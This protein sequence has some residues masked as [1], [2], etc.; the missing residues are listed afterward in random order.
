VRLPAVLAAATLAAAVLP[1]A[2]PAAAAAQ[3]PL[4]ASRDTARDA[5][6]FSFEARGPYRAAVPRPEA[7]LGY[8]LGDRNT[9]Y[10]EQE[11]VLLAIARAAPDRVRVE[12]I[13]AT[14]EGRRMRVYVVSS[15]ENVARLDAIR[16]DL[17]RLADP[18]TL[19]AADAAALAARTPAVVWISESV[20]G[21]ES[22]GFETGMQLL[23]QLAAS[24]E[25]ATLA[26]LRGAVVVINPSS[27]PDGHERFAVWYNSVARSD[28]AN[29]AAEHREPWSIQG[30]VQP[31]PV[32][33]EPR[34]D[35]Q[36]A[37]RGA[38]DH[39][40]H[41][42]LAPAGGRRPAR[43]GGHLLLPARGRAGQPQHR[44]GEREVAHGHRPRQRGGV[45]PL[46]LAVLRARP[47]R[48]VLP[49]LLGHLAVAHRRHRDDVRDRRRRLEGAALAARRR[50]AAVVPRRHRQALGVGD[51][52]DRGDGAARRP[53]ARR[54]RRLPPRGVDAGRAGPMR[55]VVW[56][57]APTR[58]AP[59]S[60][61]RRSCAPASR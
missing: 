13:G 39:A 51:G 27:N 52:D 7:L 61:R 37:A 4:A 20:H 22:P 12:E 38:G 40:R 59:P 10:A 3:P 24:E 11:R 47:V 35:R 18:R 5:A 60:W 26:A 29:D 30:P 17:A 50:L 33:H 53:S 57:P 41:A 6:R 2:R 49:G 48:P 56:C 28:P 36:H 43:A 16:A 42:A 54:L 46:R 45:R 19:G 55:Q 32:R 44:P 31:L 15:A 34:P 14:H 58:S 23:Y 9:Q 25:P 21:N 1:A 8:R